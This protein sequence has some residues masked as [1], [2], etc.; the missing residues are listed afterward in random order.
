MVTFKYLCCANNCFGMNN[1]KNKYDMRKTVH[2]C[3]FKV[4]R[5]YTSI[6]LYI[7]YGSWKMA[8]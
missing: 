3:E 5:N 7:Q 8:I 1:K 2:S 6:Y 4:N